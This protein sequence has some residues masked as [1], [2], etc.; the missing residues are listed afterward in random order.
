MKVYAKVHGY[1]RTKDAKNNFQKE[2]EGE[3]RYKRL[4]GELDA[5]NK[6]T[7]SNMCV[8]HARRGRWKE[9]V[10][11]AEEALAVDPGYVKAL[12]HKGRAM[13]EMS[14]YQGAIEVLQR[15]CEIEKEN[16]EVKKELARAEAA[17]KKYQEKEQKMF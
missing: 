10:R 1:F 9:V 5:V 3:E 11:Y 15:A 17:L 12:Y 13:V 16:P 6:T 7:L 8:I 2:D 14:E 4:E